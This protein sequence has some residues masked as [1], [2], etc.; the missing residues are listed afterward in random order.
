MIDRIMSF[1]GASVPT[2][3]A[4]KGLQQ[5]SPKI[6]QFLQGSFQA[7]Y[8]AKQALSYLRGQAGIDDEQG[9]RPDQRENRQNVNKSQAYGRLAKAG[10]AA[11]LGLGASGALSAGKVEDSISDQQPEMQDQ[12]QQQPDRPTPPGRSPLGMTGLVQG[13]ERVDPSQLKQPPLRRPGQPTPKA[14]AVQQE[15]V[16]QRNP[17]EEIDPK[18]H[19][20]IQ[21]HINRGQSAD[22]AA[23]LAQDSGHYTKSISKLKKKTGMSFSEIVNQFYKTIR[24]QTQPQQTFAYPG[25]GKAVSPEMQAPLQQIQAQQQAPRQQSRHPMDEIAAEMNQ[26][27]PSLKPGDE[28][29]LQILRQIQSMRGRQ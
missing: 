15:A 6:K 14:E 10:G 4:I 5:V 7:G 1:L 23:V 18:L 9:L 11:L 24:T 20:Y 29:M 19:T 17:I 28:A 12:I 25:K 22:V 13:A 16:L 3:L 8:T 27:E 26:R 2:A 21:S